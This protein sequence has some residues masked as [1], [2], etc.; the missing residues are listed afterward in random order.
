MVARIFW[1]LIRADGM[2]GACPAGS[3]ELSAGQRHTIVFVKYFEKHGLRGAKPIHRFRRGQ[4]RAL[5]LLPGVSKE[6]LTVYYPTTIIDA[7]TF[8]GASPRA[9]AGPRLP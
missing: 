5:P 3:R 2:V 8:E 1:P 7:A 4:R 9:P 6:N